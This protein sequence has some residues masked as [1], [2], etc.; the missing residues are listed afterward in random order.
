[1]GFYEARTHLSELLDHVAKTPP[2]RLLFSDE[3]AVA[4]LAPGEARCNDP[5]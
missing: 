5:H 1:M 4:I 3:S 2:C